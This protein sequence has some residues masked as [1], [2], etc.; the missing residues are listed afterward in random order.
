MKTYLHISMGGTI[1]AAPYP[2]DKIDYPLYST[3]IHTRAA[4]NALRSLMPST[5]ALEHVF[6]CDKDSKDLDERDIGKLY[7]TVKKRGDV[8]AA[9]CRIIVTMG[10]DRM[11]EIA[12]GL[13]KKIHSLSCPVVFTGAIWPLSNGEKSDGP[14]NLRKAA[15]DQ[16]DAAPGIYI[17]MGDV[18]APAVKVQKDYKKR[19]FYIEP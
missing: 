1:D 4:E 7:E 13:A 8:P 10:T 14:V 16:P 15:L 5:G 18:F 17:A 9:L 6:I 2:E 3:H 12:R 19:E 11:V